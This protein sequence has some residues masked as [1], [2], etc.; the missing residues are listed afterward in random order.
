[1]TKDEAIYKA[2]ILH[3]K[4]VK[5]EIKNQLKVMVAAIIDINDLVIEYGEFDSYPSCHNWQK[6]YCREKKKKAVGK[7]KAYCW[8]GN[9]ETEIYCEII[10]SFCGSSPLYFPFTFLGKT[11]KEAGQE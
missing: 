9:D 5:A 7:Y 10:K 2:R 3:D 1:M 6:K 4:C 8:F 11:I